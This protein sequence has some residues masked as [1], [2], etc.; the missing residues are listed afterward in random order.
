M[1]ISH[2]NTLSVV[3]L[4]C[5]SP[6]CPVPPDNYEYINDLIVR[7]SLNHRTA[8]W[9][10]VPLYAQWLAAHTHTHRIQCI[11]YSRL[12][13]TNN[14]SQRKR[15][16]LFR[17]HKPVVSKMLCWW[18]IS[19]TFV[20]RAHTREKRESVSEEKPPDPAWNEWLLKPNRLI[21]IIP[22]HVAT[23]SFYWWQKR[24]PFYCSSRS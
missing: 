19:F 3:T 17:G 6:H 14:G 22:I 9:S 7:I 5:P 13:T 16:K 18:S 24:L 11:R 23:P 15:R 4:V 8:H 1:Q 20:V 2:T 12:Q 21:M 10:P